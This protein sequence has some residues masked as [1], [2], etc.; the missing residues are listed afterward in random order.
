VPRGIVPDP[1]TGEDAAAEVAAAL[2][3]ALP[4]RFP[5]D[6]LVHWGRKDSRRLLD[7][8]VARAV[9]VGAAIRR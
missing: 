9:G 6:A 3:Q 8:A 5:D 4:G 7:E 2:H 1:G